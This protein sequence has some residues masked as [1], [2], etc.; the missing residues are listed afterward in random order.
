[1]PNRDPTIFAGHFSA[2][3]QRRDVPLIVRVLAYFAAITLLLV[4]LASLAAAF[5]S[6]I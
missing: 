3:P 6:I 4:W 5:K 1:M 2:P